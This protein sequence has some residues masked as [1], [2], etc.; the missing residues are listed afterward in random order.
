MVHN[1]QLM[2]KKQSELYNHFD[3]T[4]ENILLGKKTFFQKNRYKTQIAYNQLFNDF[5]N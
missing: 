4:N 1:V 3:L 2:P 5:N